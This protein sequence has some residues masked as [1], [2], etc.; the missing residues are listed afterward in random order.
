MSEKTK[1]ESKMIKLIYFVL[2]LMLSIGCQESSSILGPEFPSSLEKRPDPLSSD[3]TKSKY[4]FSENNIV[5]GDSGGVLH[6][7]YSYLNDDLEKVSLTAK[8]IIPE[9]AFEGE[10]EFKMF[11]DIE[12]YEIDLYPSPYSVLIWA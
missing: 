6:V 12:N 7:K 10:L 5:N 8:L 4:K 11:F 9:G 1:G 2:L 3:L